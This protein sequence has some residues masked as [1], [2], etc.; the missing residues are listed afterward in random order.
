MRSDFNEIAF[1]QQTLQ[2]AELMH[3]IFYILF[4]CP[5]PRS[6]TTSP[7]SNSKLCEANELIEKGDSRATK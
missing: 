2:F 4:Y 7:E 6:G 3:T 5:H 1:S